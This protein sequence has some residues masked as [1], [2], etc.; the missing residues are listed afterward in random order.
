MAGRRRKVPA[1]QKLVVGYVR[2]STDEQALGP[3]AQREA[4]ESWCS[5]EAA[6][7]V[8]VF[9]DLGVSGGTPVEKRPGLNRALDAINREGAGEHRANPHCAQ[10]E[11]LRQRAA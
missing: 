3:E 8:A 9:A 4:I 5:R 2:V 11:H 1:D 10:V 6:E 7:L